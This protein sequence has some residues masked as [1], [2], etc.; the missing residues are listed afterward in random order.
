MSV[1]T[2]GIWL[3]HPG[4]ENDFVQAWRDLARKTRDDFPHAKAV[5]M[6]DRDV[7][8]R[9][10]STGPWESLEQIEQWRASETFQQSMSGLHEMLEHF[11]ARTLDEAA[12]I[13]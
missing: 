1:Y 8:N 9:F 10:I 13:G 5:L 6:H 4:R 3:V 2:L 7:Q 12:S 11:E